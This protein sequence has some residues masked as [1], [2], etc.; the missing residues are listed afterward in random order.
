MTNNEKRSF[1]NANDLIDHLE[2]HMLGVYGGSHNLRREI[3]WSIDKVEA[4]IRA[5]FETMPHPVVFSTTIKVADPFERPSPEFMMHIGED[6]W[7]SFGAIV[8]QHPNAISSETNHD[9]VTGA[10]N[11]RSSLRILPWQEE[12]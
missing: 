3:F 10:I 5:Y 4:A 12:R 7:R 2:T 6:I 9:I 8:L 1:P 11:V